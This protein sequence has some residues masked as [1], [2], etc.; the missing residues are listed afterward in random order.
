MNLVKRYLS[1]LILVFFTLS[2][3]TGIMLDEPEEVLE[4]AVRVCLSC[5]GIE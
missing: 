5:I 3:L 2:L 1:I 4:L